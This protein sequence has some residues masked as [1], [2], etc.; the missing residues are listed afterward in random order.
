[1]KIELGPLK[2]ECDSDSDV[3]VYSFIIYITFMI[4]FSIIFFN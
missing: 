1:M 2:F 4:L 3:L